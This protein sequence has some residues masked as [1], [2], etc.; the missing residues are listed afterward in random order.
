MKIMFLTDLSII[1]FEIVFIYLFIFC[2][3]TLHFKPSNM[4]L[5]YTD[6]QQENRF[7]KRSTIM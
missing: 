1:A 3:E 4:W 2:N 7:E 6:V 5:T